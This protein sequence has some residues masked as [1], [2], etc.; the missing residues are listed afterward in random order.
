MQQK[1]LVMELAARQEI[2]VPLVTEAL[3][4]RDYMLILGGADS[5]RGEAL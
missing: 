3:Y 2:S 1:N 4:L 5:L